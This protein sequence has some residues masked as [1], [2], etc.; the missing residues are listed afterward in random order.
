MLHQMRRRGL[1]MPPLCKP[2]AFEG[3]GRTGKASTGVL[4]FP[5]RGAVRFAHGR[6]PLLGDLTLRRGDLYFLPFNASVAPNGGESAR[7]EL[8]QAAC[9]EP[10]F[11]A[12]NVWLGK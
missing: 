8:Q 7:L 5:D 11:V 9:D 1:G 4:K 2:I 3:E 12:R 6:S 10:N